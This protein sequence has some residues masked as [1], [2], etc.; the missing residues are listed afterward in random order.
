MGERDVLGA[1]NSLVNVVVLR[2]AVF[3]TVAQEL[4]KCDSKLAEEQYVPA[5]LQ[6]IFVVWCHKT[7]RKTRK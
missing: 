6:M 7:R 1:A 4:H 5:H 2:L 3:S